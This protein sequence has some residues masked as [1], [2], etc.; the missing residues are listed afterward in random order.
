MVVIKRHPP[1]SRRTVVSPQGHRRA[2]LDF[3]MPRRTTR[4]WQKATLSRVDR[5]RDRVV[6]PKQRVVGPLGRVVG[7]MGH[8]VSPDG[9]GVSPAERA[10]GPQQRAVGLNERITAR[11]HVTTGLGAGA[12][13]R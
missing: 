5:P 4:G 13:R 1:G 6:R 3:S 7:P 8:V 12:G 9:H 10:F 2:N 11:F